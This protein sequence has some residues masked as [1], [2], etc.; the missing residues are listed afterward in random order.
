MT[1]SLPCQGRNHGCYKK[2]KNSSGTNDNQ[3]K[4]YG[5]FQNNKIVQLMVKARPDI[6]PKRAMQ[7]RSSLHYV[8]G[9]REGKQAIFFLFNRPFSTE[10]DN[11]CYGTPR[12]KMYAY[13]EY[14]SDRTK[15]RLSTGGGAKSWYLSRYLWWTYF[16]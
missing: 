6:C 15:T 9:R 5:S 2:L 8:S 10:K 4:A 7:S 11:N 13:K 12:L 14:M 3:R 16:T 1:E